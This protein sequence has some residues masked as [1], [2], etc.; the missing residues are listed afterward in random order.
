[1]ANAQ[2]GSGLPVAASI[3]DKRSVHNSGA[4]VLATPANYSSI[5]AMRTR[6]NAISATSY[7]AA[8][9]DAMTVND[10]VYAIRLSDDAAGI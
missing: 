9:L 7:S 2:T 6:L 8:R 5:F 3:V 10:M 4:S 1:M